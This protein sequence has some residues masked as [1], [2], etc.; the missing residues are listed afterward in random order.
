MDSWKLI[1]KHKC[2]KKAETAKK[3]IPSDN[4]FVLHEVDGVLKYKRPDS[5]EDTQR[6][7]KV[8]AKGKLKNSLPFLQQEFIRNNT[9]FFI[10]N[11]EQTALQFYSLSKLNLCYVLN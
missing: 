11:Y 2:I 4:S 9:S 3:E 7:K 8:Q 6:K 10:R 5:E 1:K